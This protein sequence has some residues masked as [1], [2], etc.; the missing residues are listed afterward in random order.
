MLV[1]VEVGG[2]TEGVSVGEILYVSID[3]DASSVTFV[4]SRSELSCTPVSMRSAGI[5]LCE[6]RVMP[7]RGVVSSGGGVVSSS[8]DCVSYVGSRT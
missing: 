4:D 5:M 2:R 6:L 7:G 1:G 3:S 8:P